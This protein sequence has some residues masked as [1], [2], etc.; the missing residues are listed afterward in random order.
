MVASIEAPFTPLQK[1]IKGSFDPVKPSQMTLRLVPEVFYSIDV[2]SLF[3]KYGGVVDAPVLKV[4][5][6]Q[7]I[8]RFEGVCVHHTLGLNLILYDW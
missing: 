2:I 7:G 8:V 1:P 3:C 6:V 4:A 5:H